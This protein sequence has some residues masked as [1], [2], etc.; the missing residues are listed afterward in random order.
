MPKESLPSVELLIEQL[1][2]AD[3]TARYDGARLPDL[4]DSITRLMEPLASNQAL[5]LP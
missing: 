4:S 5:T 2:G 3:W 1:H